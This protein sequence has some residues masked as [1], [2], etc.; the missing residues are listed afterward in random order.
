VVHGHDG[1]DELS[2][3]G[4]SIVAELKDGAVREFAVK[5]EDAGLARARLEDLIGGDTAE[6]AAAIRETLAGAPGP[7]RDIVLLNAAAALV[8]ADNAATLRE[9][10]DLAAQAIESGAATGALE[11]LAAICG[12]PENV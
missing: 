11:K 8:V 7:L 5:P 6:N 1:L 12:A 10:A 4:E 2:T 9:G 3:T